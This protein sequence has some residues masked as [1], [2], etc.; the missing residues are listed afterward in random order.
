M[1][2]KLKSIFMKENQVKLLK[3]GFKKVEREHIFQVFG[4]LAPFR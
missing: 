1:S 4:H 3:I 2:S